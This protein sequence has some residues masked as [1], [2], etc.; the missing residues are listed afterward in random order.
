M[1]LAFTLTGISYVLLQSCSVIM[2]L[3]LAVS[4]QSRSLKGMICILH[5]HLEGLMSIWRERHRERERVLVW[6][7][8]EALCQR[9]LNRDCWDLART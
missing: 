9:F 2:V 3:V 8:N 5:L 1:D 6:T 7:A 4:K